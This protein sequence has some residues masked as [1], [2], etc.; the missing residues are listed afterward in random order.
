MY[1]YI[2]SLGVFQVDV[3][4]VLDEMSFFFGFKFLSEAGDAE[5]PGWIA[6]QATVIAIYNKMVHGQLHDGTHLLRRIEP[7]HLFEAQ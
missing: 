4:D 1:D 2:T 5:E 6:W 7:W 3:I